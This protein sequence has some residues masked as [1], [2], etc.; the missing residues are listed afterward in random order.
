MKK[1]VNQINAE[2][3]GVFYLKKVLTLD[4]VEKYTGFKKSYL[5][6]LTSSKILPHNKPT[7]GAIFIVREDLE[8]W[9]IRNRIKTV[10]EIQREVNR[11]ELKQK[12]IK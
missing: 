10:A 4:E 1:E 11:F 9:L 6:K 5:Y 3:N 7:N 12:R 2:E 8:K